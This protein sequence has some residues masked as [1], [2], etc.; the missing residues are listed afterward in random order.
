MTQDESDVY[1]APANEQQELHNQFVEQLRFHYAHAEMAQAI[2]SLTAALRFMG[3][4][5]L[6]Q[7]AIEKEMATCAMRVANM[8]KA[9][10]TLVI[11]AIGEGSR[12]AHLAEEPI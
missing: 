2:D 6:M 7:P 5:V 8:T 11:K 4:S 3:H 9:C 12:D 1:E 10:V